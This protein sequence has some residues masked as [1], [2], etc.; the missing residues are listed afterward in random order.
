[1]AATGLMLHCGASAISRGELAA[2]PL[3]AP[4][5]PRHVIRPYIEDVELVSD[6]LN[7]YGLGVV[8]EAFGATHDGARFFGVLE[9][10]PLEGELLSPKEY[11]LLVGIRGSYDQ[12]MSRGIAAGS[13]VFVCDNLSFSGEVS[14]QTRQ[15]T[16]IGDRL[17]GLLVD[18]V[19]KV[20]AMARHQHQRFEAYKGTRL[21]QRQGDAAII[22]LV[23]RGVINPS[24]VGKVIQEWDEPSHEE[25]ASDGFTAWR[26]YNAVTESLKPSN[27][28]RFAVPTLWQR[29]IPLSD[30][31]DSAAGFVTAMAA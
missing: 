19:A 7:E 6:A 12:S 9:C 31:M 11:S 24:I 4:M 25:H 15:T 8:D 3:P 1:M 20:P 30:F 27:K 16:N 2:M 22:E 18:A 28:D 21:T 29:T 13:R 10:K 23:R 17:P 5:G 14:I 26:L